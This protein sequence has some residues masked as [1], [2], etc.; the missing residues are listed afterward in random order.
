MSR[1]DKVGAD[2][3]LLHGFPQNCMPNIVEG[4]LEDY[5][6]RPRPY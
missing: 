3:V 5:E 6:D 4:R 2:V 1:S